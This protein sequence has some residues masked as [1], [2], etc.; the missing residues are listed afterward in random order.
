MLSSCPVPRV[1]GHISFRSDWELVK[2]DFRP[3][4][5]RPCSKEDYGS[6]DLTSLQVEPLPLGLLDPTL[7]SGRLGGGLLQRGLRVARCNGPQFPCL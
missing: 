3:S 1:F 7:C 6:W 4:F 5:S 2:V